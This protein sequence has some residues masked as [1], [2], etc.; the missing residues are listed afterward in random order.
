MYPKKW[1]YAIFLQYSILLHSN[2]LLPSLKNKN[3]FLYDI[4]NL[5]FSFL[6]EHL[7]VIIL[8]WVK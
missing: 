3:L 1:V 8:V 5:P 7:N 6:S 4:N 2:F